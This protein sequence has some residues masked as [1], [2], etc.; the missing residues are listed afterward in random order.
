L[1]GITGRV[2]VLCLTACVLTAPAAGAQDADAEKAPEPEYGKWEPKL[3][4]GMVLTQSAYSDNWNGSEQGQIAWN[5]ILN[6]ALTNQFNRSLN[7]RN[8]LKLA[9]GHTHNQTFSAEDPGVRVW[10]HPEKTTDL[11]DFESLLRV[12]LGRWV[13]PYVA[14]RLLS[15]FLD[16]SDPYGRDVWASPMTLT[17]SA[18]VAREFYRTDDEFF[19][20]R[21]GLAARE[22]IRQFYPFA[23]EVSD[24]RT[25][26]TSN[27]AGLEWVTDYAVK[28]LQDKVLWN[29]KLTVYK[30]LEYSF[31][32][33]MDTA[34]PDISDYPLAVDVNWENIFTGEVVSWLSLN[35]Y[36]MFVYDKYD[37]S[38]LPELDD[39]GNLLNE[40]AV[41][42]AVRKA[43]QFK[44][45]LG[46]GLTFKFL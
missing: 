19:L 8:Q 46:L 2:A 44:Q 3:D 38:V 16:N 9:F 23:P 45:T 6:S 27:D 35:V 24:E 14:F 20:S 37:N 36:V 11:I 41:N 42:A 10:D 26:E 32:G 15:Q 17:G 31:H 12:T 21:F 22:N 28:F 29:S 18:G 13:D 43:G 4:I 5:F 40:G 25:T 30:A 34:V 39:Q 1:I 7:W 33:D